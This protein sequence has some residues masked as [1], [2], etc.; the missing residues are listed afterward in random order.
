LAIVASIFAG[1]GKNEKE[2][3]VYHLDVGKDLAVERLQERAV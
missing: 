3:E 2:E 1:L